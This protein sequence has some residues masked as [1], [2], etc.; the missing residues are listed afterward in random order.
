MPTYDFICNNCNQRFDVFLT[1][2][3]YGNKTVTCAH[4]GS[5][6]VRRRM[7]KVRVAKSQESRMDDMEG[8]LGGLQGM[9]DDPKALGRMMR[10]MGQEAG[11]DLPPEFDDVVDRLESGQSPDEIESEMPELG[12]LPG[13]DDDL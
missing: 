12:S 4:C 9:E 7:T 1:F 3:E 5:D 11:E 2:S 8:D 13:G 6:K 10:K